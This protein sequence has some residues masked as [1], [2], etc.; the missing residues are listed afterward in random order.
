MP[1]LFRLCFS[2]NAV[3][4][5]FAFFLVLRVSLFLGG[6]EQALCVQLSFSMIA[7]HLW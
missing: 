3:L 6:S 7:F 2:F 4:G 5:W 1:C